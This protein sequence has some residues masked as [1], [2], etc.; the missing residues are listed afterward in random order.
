MKKI[1]VPLTL[2]A[3]SPAA[4]AVAAHFARACHATLV[5]VHVVPCGAGEG[6]PDAARAKLPFNSPPPPSAPPTAPL[7]LAKARLR[8]LAATVS[9]GLPAEPIVCTGAPVEMILHEAREHRAG[10]IVMSTHGCRGWCK[11]LHRNTALHV[12]QH[13]PCP[14]WHI[15][16]GRHEQAFTLTLAHPDPAGPALPAPQA[17]RS[18]LQLLRLRPAPART[19]PAVFHLTLAPS[20]AVQPQSQLDELLALLRRALSRPCA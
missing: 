7:R 5:L 14:V 6:G 18:F 19:A 16:P 4:L 12:L 15:S 13:S 11:W 2:S 10:A 9:P 8:A 17:S 3:G 20:L 1:L